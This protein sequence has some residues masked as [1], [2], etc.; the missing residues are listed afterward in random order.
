[1]GGIERIAGL[2]ELDVPRGEQVSERA[3][4]GLQR[5]PNPL[6]LQVKRVALLQLALKLRSEGDG[7]AVVSQE[8]LPVHAGEYSLQVF[9]FLLHGP[10]ERAGALA[11]VVFAAKLELAPL[12]FLLL[13]VE[14][15]QEELELL[16]QFLVAF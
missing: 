2:D 15:L 5:A 14:H 9:T 7:H 12:V 16:A 10:R 8:D 11:R 3:A 13:P 1:M 4:L 6:H